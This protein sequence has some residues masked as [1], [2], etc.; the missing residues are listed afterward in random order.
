MSFSRVARAIRASVV[1]AVAA[2]LVPAIAGSAQADTAPPSGTP[3]TVSADALP[4]WQVNGVVWEQAIAG[5]TVF[6]GGA[7]TAARPPGVNAGGAGEVA[8]NKL[9]AYDIT[10]GN[11]VASF[12]HSANGDVISVQVSPD[13]S[14]VYVGGDFTTIDGKSRNHIAAFNTSTGALLENFKPSLNG[15]VRAIALSGD[16]STVYAGGMFTSVG[17][18]ARNRLAKFTASTGALDP[19]WTPAADDGRVQSLVVAPAGDKLVVGGRFSTMNGGVSARGTGAVTTAG[20]GTI[21]PWLENQKIISGK[22]SQC[23]TTSLSTDGT[24]IYGTAFAFGCGNFEGVWAADPTTGALVFANDC[25]G[26]TYDAAPIDGVVY[27]VS[28]AHDCKWMGGYPEGIPSGLNVRRSIAF[29]TAPSGPTGFNGGFNSGPDSYGWDYRTVRHSDMLQWFPDMQTGNLTG[30]GQAAWTVSANSNYVVLGGEFP[31]VNGKKQQGLTRFAKTGVAG[32]PNAQGPVRAT[33]APDPTAAAQSAASI[34]VTW[35]SAFDKDNANLTYDIYRS[36]TTAP[37]GSVTAASSYW[38]YPNQTFTDQGLTGGTYTYTVKARDPLGNT[39]TL[40]ATNSVTVAGN[41]NQPPVAS[42]TGTQTD[43]NTLTVNFDGTGSSDP[44]G[45]VARYDWDYGDGQSDANAGATPSHAYGAAGTYNATLTVTD[46]QGAKSSLTKSVTVTAPNRAPTADFSFDHTNNVATFNGSGSS[47]PDAGDTL[48]YDWDFGDPNAAAHGSGATPSHTYQA[49]GT[50]DVTL[51]VT[52]NHGAASTPVTKQVTVD[53]PPPPGGPTQ[54]AA[55][56][57]GRTSTNSWG[58]AD[59]GG[60]WTVSP[61]SSFKVSGGV[62]TMTM[63]SA[64]AQRTASLNSV[65]TTSSD[66]QLTVS[67]D[68]LATGGGTSA[69]ILARQVGS[70]SYRT[71]LNFRADG[72]VTLNLTKVDG[73]TTTTLQAAKAISGLKYAAGDTLNLRV[74]AVGT[75]PT[76]L[77]ARVW[78]VGQTEPTGWQVSATDSGASLQSAGSVGLISYL[79]GTA[80]AAP[81]TLAYDNLRV[82]ATARQPAP[83]S[84]PDPAGMI[85]AW[86]WVGSCR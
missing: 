77:Q 19:L 17:G 52:D 64:G 13:N 62:G 15:S 39:I 61:T 54:I 26:D 38:N 50:Y 76:T 35:Q 78:K 10:T 56:D 41:G 80:T 44:N 9:F 4:N 27:T 86:L 59:Q 68:Q 34:K 47:D 32:N 1:L 46:N 33:G 24:N 75:S 51:T 73:G 81:V 69:T 31:S 55:D 82:Y 42:F 48:A 30:Q 21:L 67:P 5:N 49:A 83:P 53:D 43:P 11:R 79:S 70:A 40:P 37:V 45:T 29:T 12:S 72:T 20:A 71:T 58:S 57:F 74:Q 7:F 65:S 16:G 25:H 28:H 6:A 2:A 60:A 63:P 18:S 36:G 84:G 23:G 66:T 3:A 85:S 8:A 22:D 14:V